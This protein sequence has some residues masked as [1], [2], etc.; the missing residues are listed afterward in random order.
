MTRE[1]EM[2]HRSVESHVR[3]GFSRSAT[4]LVP[5][6]R[7]R[8]ATKEQL[9]VPRNRFLQSR[10]TIEADGDELSS[11]LEDSP[12]SARG[13]IDTRDCFFES[14]TRGIPFGRIPAA[15]AFLIFKNKQLAAGRS[16][17]FQDNGRRARCLLSNHAAAYFWRRTEACCNGNH[18]SSTLWRLSFAR[19]RGSARFSPYEN[20]T[21]FL[22]A[23]TLSREL[24]ERTPP[25]FVA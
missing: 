1:P 5:L 4:N 17:Q 23:S 6:L 22:E 19:F 15:D 10:R 25:R 21:S 11:P 13:E 16:E 24:S 20:L 14:G 3:S 9:V 2:I 12:A 7:S 8:A 18:Y